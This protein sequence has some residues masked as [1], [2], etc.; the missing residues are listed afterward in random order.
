ML[1]YAVVDERAWRECR[2]GPG[3]GGYGGALAPPS[4]FVSDGRHRRGE[5]GVVGADASAGGRPSARLCGRSTTGVD[6]TPPIYI[7]PTHPLP[8]RATPAAHH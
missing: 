6:H 7:P 3:L 5:P 8:L 4:V 1:C 2:L